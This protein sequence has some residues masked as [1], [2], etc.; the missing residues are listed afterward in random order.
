MNLSIGRIVIVKMFHILQQKVKLWFNM[1]KSYH[2]LAMPI[3]IMNHRGTFFLVSWQ[4]RL[5]R[6]NHSCV[7]TKKIDSQNLQV[8]QQILCLIYFLHHLTVVTMCALNHSWLFVEINLKIFLKTKVECRKSLSLFAFW[9]AIFSFGTK[10]PLED[11]IK[12][13][14]STISFSYYTQALKLWPLPS[15]LKFPICCQG[16]YSY[17]FSNKSNKSA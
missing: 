13:V 8:W 2:N 15:L 9:N 14:R 12:M 11:H 17:F 4:K 16:S 10:K 3:L 5:W 7:R 6:I 1:S